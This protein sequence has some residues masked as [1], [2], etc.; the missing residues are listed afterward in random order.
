M[1][2]TTKGYA[3]DVELLWLA[4]RL[5]LRREVVAVT[6]L[7]VPGS[8]VRPV[9]DSARM[10]L[11]IAAAR[12][13]RRFLAVAEVGDGPLDAPAPDGS[14]RVVVDDGVLLCG[15]VSQTGA[16]RLAVGGRASVRVASL[17]ELT[18]RVPRRVELAS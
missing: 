15:A 11:D 6:W 18:A 1:L 10:L 8:T 5:N 3:F 7:D 16:L 12:R 13:H 4:S 14:V 17:A 9:H 2:Q